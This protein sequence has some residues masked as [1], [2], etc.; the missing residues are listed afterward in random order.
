[1]HIDISLRRCP[2]LECISAHA[3]RA[4]ARAIGSSGHMPGCRSARYSAIASESQTT[5]SPSCRQGTRADGEN[6]RFSG[7]GSA[8]PRSDT[9]TSRNG[10]P[11]SLAMSQPRSDHD[12]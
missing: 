4:N 5:V 2:K 12:E 6:A 1:M 8:S 10:A 3:E 9:I 7:F 11:D